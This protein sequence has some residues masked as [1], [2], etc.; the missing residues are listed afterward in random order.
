MFSIQRNHLSDQGVDYITFGKG[1]KTLI[2]ITGLSLQRLGDMS[3]LT[4]YSLFSRYAREYKV[5]IFDR[6]NHIEEGV[7]IEDNNPFFIGFIRV[8]AKRFCG[9]FK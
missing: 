9:L 4:I 3:N 8:I 7:S 2:I 6:K 5:Y 1:N